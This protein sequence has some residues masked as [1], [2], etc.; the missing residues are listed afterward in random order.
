MV[1]A[2]KL[3]STFLQSPTEAQAASLLS[4]AAKGTGMAP[5]ER[6]HM[7]DR[8]VC[9]SR[10]DSISPSSPALANMWSPT[11][12]RCWKIRFKKSSS[13]LWVMRE[14]EEMTPGEM[15]QLKGELRQKKTGRRMEGAMGDALLQRNSAKCGRNLEDSTS[16]PPSISPFPDFVVSTTNPKCQ[17]FTWKLDVKSAPSESA[18]WR[19]LLKDWFRSRVHCFPYKDSTMCC[20]ITSTARITPVTGEPFTA[21][22]RVLPKNPTKKKDSWKTNKVIC[23]MGTVQALI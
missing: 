16:L 19:T 15:I 14:E 2:Q 21:H 6:E 4:P 18:L 3:G 17:E 20:Y 11:W 12:L 9:T 22:Q 1:C 7:R 5:Q 23:T 8:A 13:L 10:R